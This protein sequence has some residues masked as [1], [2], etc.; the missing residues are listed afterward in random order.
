MSISGSMSEES[1]KVG[2]RESPGRV[3][4]A[5]VSVKV[6]KRECWCAVCYKLSWCVMTPILKKFLFLSKR[7]LKS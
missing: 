2:S 7:R 1:V 3:E 4:D 6:M 5:L